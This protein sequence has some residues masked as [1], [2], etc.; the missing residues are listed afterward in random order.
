MWNQRLIPA[1]II[2]FLLAVSGA[3]HADTIFLKSSKTIEGEIVY[4][5]PIFVR[6]KTDTL[7]MKEHLRQLIDHI[8]FDQQREPDDTWN[9]NG[10][11]LS[12]DP[13]NPLDTVVL[14]SGRVITGAIVRQTPM[15]VRIQTIETVGLQDFLIV[16]VARI[17]AQHRGTQGLSWQTSGTEIDANKIIDDYDKNVE[18]DRSDI[19]TNA[20]ANTEIDPDQKKITPYQKVISRDSPEPY[21][22][23]TSYSQ[24]VDLPQMMPAMPDYSNAQAQVASQMD[25]MDAVAQAPHIYNTEA[26]NDFLDET[27]TSSPTHKG[28]ARRQAKLMEKAMAAQAKVASG[29]MGQNPIDKFKELIPQFLIAILI[30]IAVPF[31]IGTVLFL[32]SLLKTTTESKN[33]KEIKDELEALEK[34]KAEDKVS[35][36]EYT[37][38]TGEIE[39]RLSKS[40]IKL[41]LLSI[42]KVF[43]YPVRGKVLLA[44]IAASVMFYVFRVAM[45]APF[46]GFFAMIFAFCYLVACIV[47][48]IETAVREEREDV[49]DWPS[50]TEMVDWFGK[51][52][53]F[54]VGWL[55][56]HGT[57]FLIFANFI[58]Y[59]ETRMIVVSVSVAF[60]IIGM[61][62]YPMY[63]LSMTLVGGTA[64]LN[65]INIFKAINVTFVSYTL[66]S[67]LLIVT[68]LLS[69]WAHTIPA[70][71]IPLFGGI[72]K[73][74]I[75]VYFLLV[76]MR[77]LGVFYKTHRLTLQWYGEDK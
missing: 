55:I 56:C 59:E 53:L 36:E 31:F 54:L 68:Q 19:S 40:T 45:Y 73:W 9:L 7:S 60:L 29:K 70:I 50:F 26:Y 37:N 74:F 62:V 66:T 17:N 5:S 76:N 13:K 67:V 22:P 16:D 10:P 43:I 63:I 32:I 49:F 71:G 25:L 65:I 46:Y 28:E 20:G 35:D 77:L 2:A 57:A 42:P 4:E 44:T 30:G 61:F 15:F 47:K 14:K 75:F 8:E 51:A 34:L 41:F 24:T 3:C 6:I 52:F 58:R 21:Q 23:R 64:S 39:N 33:N 27:I 69:V 12:E 48:I 11:E 38:L 1:F 18:E 72:L